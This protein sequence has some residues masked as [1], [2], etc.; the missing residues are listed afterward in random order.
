MLKP[1]SLVFRHHPTEQAFRKEWI[2]AQAIPL[3]PFLDKGHMC[4]M[5]PHRRALDS[6][7]RWA[8]CQRRRPHPVTLAVDALHLDNS[9]TEYQPALRLVIRVVQSGGD[10]VLLHVRL[11]GI[12]PG[13]LW[14]LCKF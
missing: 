2:A 7:S 4:D 9:L 10:C 12:L 3:M 1:T 14:V 8:S 13:M 6:T 5:S 11:P